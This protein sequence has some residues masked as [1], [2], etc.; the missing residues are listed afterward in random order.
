[1]E[2]TVER[3]LGVRV[4][5]RADLGS[6]NLAPVARL[7]LDREYDGIGRTV[8]VK[9]RR[10]D[11][12]AWGTGDAF[13]RN[14]RRALEHLQPTGLAPKLL[15]TSVGT[16]EYDQVLVLSDLGPGPTVQQLLFGDD[17][18][19]AT[20]GL[21][22]MARLAA[23][24]HTAVDPD[25]EAAHEI[26][27]LDQPLNLWPPL[28]EAAAEL[29]FPPPGDVELRRLADDLQ[30]RTAFTHGDFTPGNVVLGNGEARLVDL[31][32]AGR[33][34]P[35]LDAACLRL[36]FPHYG[37]WATIPDQVLNQ[38]DATYRSATGDPAHDGMMATGSAAWA[39]I[40]ASRLR[41]I[42]SS[43]QAPAEALRR[44]TQIVHTL[45][46][47]A[48]CMRAVYP[49]LSSWLDQL[50]D[51]MRLRWAEARQPP[52]TFQGFRSV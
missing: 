6:S 42:A 35:G 9:G 4:V 49:N 34:H 36:P 26:Q 30:R 51:A 24:L 12:L 48:A 10:L 5:D 20:E 1:M 52:R 38:L 37:Y 50:S 40:R 11:N 21:L 25:F 17:P 46:A 44:R 39:I 29:D 7:V 19:A 14:E 13:Q 27:F 18:E 33:R 41:L 45:T 3:L 43:D 8:I 32:G 22:A 23:E 28:V 2:R 15:A 31:E 16:D 47:A